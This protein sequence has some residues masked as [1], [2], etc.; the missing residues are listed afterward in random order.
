MR[1]TGVYARFFRSLNFDYVS[2]SDPAFEANPWDVLPSGEA[3]P[4]VFL[5]LESDITTVVGG[6]ESGKSQIL[7]ASLAALTGKGFAQSDF[8][9]YSPF[10]S[11]DPD[12]VQPEFGA[13]LEDVSAQDLEHLR[14]ALAGPID[15]GITQAALFRVNAT[16]QLR[17]YLRSS[18]DE[19]WQEPRLVKKPTSLTA[20]GVPLP[21]K[22][23]A[24]IP[25][26]DSVPLEY[27][28]TG[29]S[30]KTTGRSTTK[31]LLEMVAKNS[32]WFGSP[33]AV[34]EN[35]AKIAE[36][37]ADKMPVDES[38]L[39]GW[40][41]AGDLLH[42]VAKVKRE[43]FAELRQHVLSKS[44]YA[45]SIV[46]TINRDLANALNF[47]H[48]WSQDS[49]FELFV[50]VFEFDLVF[51]IRDRT[52]RSYGFDERSDG[53]KYFLSYFVQYLA[54]TPPEDGSRELLLMDEPDRYLSNA[55]QQDLL[56]VFADF[57]A[58]HE[59]DRR[60]I[61][62]L[63]V[64]HSPFLIDKNHAERIRVL[65][66]GEHDEGT[67][68]VSKVSQNHYEPL[69]SAFG[70]FVGET[71]FIG[72]CNLMLEGPSDQ[73]LLAGVSRWLGRRGTPH[74]RRLD[75]NHLTL[76][77]AAG[78]SQVPYLIYLARGRD[79][80][81]P[82]VIALLDGDESGR[83]A[84]ATIKRGGARR[85]AL[86]DDSLVLQTSDDELRQVKTGNPFGRVAIEDLIPFD[87]ALSALA[88]YCKE[89]VPEVD[90]ALLAQIDESCY[91]LKDKSRKN[92]PEAGRRGL[93][94]ALE[95]AVRTATP[96]ESFE[97]DKI[98]FAR[99]VLRELS[100]RSASDASLTTLQANF[101]C[102]FAALGARQR[103]AERV[104]S[105]DRISKR[106][107]RTKD[108]FFRFHD[109]RAT[110]EDVILLIEEIT[111]QLDTSEEAEAVRSEMRLW[112]T[113][114]HLDDDV[115]EPVEDINALKSA[116]N[117]L[118]YTGQRLSAAEVAAGRV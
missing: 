28:A 84:R 63:Y 40:R 15:E 82:A 118:A 105:T 77:P 115:R 112:H 81:Q 86:I 102:L 98:A 103:S 85:K 104:E 41:L 3:Y 76:V 5:A 4:F 56:R 74:L 44:G 31:R 22:I 114:F 70:S 91:K 2:L 51:M 43:R 32:A 73:I 13:L 93:V 108:R 83:E 111:S 80:E 67:R 18:S 55:G 17:V 10:F 116:L 30:A 35:A 9:R 21:F 12:L 99:N 90:L 97:L 26:P 65:E 60:P 59:P 8:C 57:A 7:A 79:A 109:S 53:L 113:R 61:Q 25:L 75:L 58:P 42:N 37:A 45:N 24:D 14:A 100:L 54:H 6:N 66:K 92:L 34:T 23:D 49:Q 27:L 29:R 39:A 64:T 117:T 95:V 19:P 38:V 88:S 33:A 71:A 48:W 16:P 101:E 87:V 46:D 11:V 1:L 69:R 36:A 72:S 89:F 68:V 110:R 78:A 52:G 50:V 47:P 62:V 20:A 96:L 107:N 106:I 94:S